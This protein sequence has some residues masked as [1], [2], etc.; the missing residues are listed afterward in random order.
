[1]STGV[2]N[3]NATVAVMGAPSQAANSTYLQ[4]TGFKIVIDRN[5]YPN[6]EFFAQSVS[7]PSIG[8]PAV[9]TSYRNI[10]TLPMSGDKLDYGELNINALMD[11]NMLAY[12]EVYKWM[13]RIIEVPVRPVT[14]IMDKSRESHSA[15]VTVSVLSSHN[16]QIK[17]IRYIDCH[18]TLM[19]DVL[20]EST[21]GDVTYITFPVSFRFSYFRLV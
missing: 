1:M 8:L 4:P 19:G 7:H 5:N 15:D 20:F 10:A 14:K 16:N 3:H 12:T 13:E 18:P 9:E 17:Q 11:E 21:V 2:T 6:L